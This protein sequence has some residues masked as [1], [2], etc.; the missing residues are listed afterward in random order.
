MGQPEKQVRESDIGM[1]TLKR[2]AELLEAIHLDLQ[3]A[4]WQRGGC[5]G[6]QPGTKDAGTTIRS[7]G[8]NVYNI[9]AVNPDQV[10]D[11]LDRR[12]FGDGGAGMAK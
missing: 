10:R 3:T 4:N 2:I 9:T 11:A 5:K 6:P 1:K 7:F 8:G 12:Q